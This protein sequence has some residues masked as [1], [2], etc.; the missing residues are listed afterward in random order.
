MNK[1]ELDVGDGCRVGRVGDVYVRSRDW[2]AI[3]DVAPV[4][5]FD[6][7]SNSATFKNLSLEEAARV[8]GITL[9]DLYAWANDV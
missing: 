8:T 3:I 7:W 6:R 4:F 9:S 5:G 2:G 1:T